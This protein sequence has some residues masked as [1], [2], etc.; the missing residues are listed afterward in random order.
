VWALDHRLADE[1]ECIRELINR[2]QSASICQTAL[3]SGSFALAFARFR[4]MMSAMSPTFHT[5]GIYTLRGRQ[6]PN[7]GPHSIRRATEP[8]AL[9]G[10]RRDGVRRYALG[11]CSRWSCDCRSAA[12]MVTT[13]IINGSNLIRDSSDGL[14]KPKN[15]TALS[16]VCLGSNASLE[17]CWHVGYTFDSGRIDARQRTASGH[18]CLPGLSGLPPSSHLVPRPLSPLCPPWPPH[19]LLAGF[20]LKDAYS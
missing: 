17:L 9:S 11:G 13:R 7:Y 18:K 10:T 19:R 14:Q 2:P 20:A 3:K 6:F 15:A 16:E 4:S 5:P 1:R 8:V 12:S